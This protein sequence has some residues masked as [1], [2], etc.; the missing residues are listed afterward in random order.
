[1]GFS[2]QVQVLLFSNFDVAIEEI[3]MNSTYFRIMLVKLNRMNRKK[4]EIK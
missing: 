2:K 3:K 1:M 4:E